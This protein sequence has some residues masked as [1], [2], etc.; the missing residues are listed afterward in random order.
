MMDG[1]ASGDLEYP[2]YLVNGR[3]ANNPETFEVR[4]GDRVRLRLVNPASDT[5]FRFAVGG[6]RLTVT[7]ADGLPVEHVTVDA[8]KI[9]MGERYDVVLE[10]NSPGA[11]QMAAAPEG[12]SGL[13]RTV[14]RYSGSGESSAPPADARPQ[15]LDGRLLGYGVSLQRETRPSP[16][17][18][19]LGGRI[20]H[21]TSPSPAATATTCGT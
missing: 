6:H 8:L 20:A 13:A 16:R 17:T 4:R 3:T 15:E 12:K 10:A 5:A 1:G 7:H 2:L 19:S 11:W 21:W 9:G 14:L 18:A